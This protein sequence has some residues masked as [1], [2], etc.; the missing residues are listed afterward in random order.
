MVMPNILSDTT[1]R[2][3]EQAGIGSETVL[4]AGEI[5]YLRSTANLSTGGTAID[6]T[7]VV[8]PD[9]SPCIARGRHSDRFPVG[10]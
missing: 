7:D 5:F 10:A 1:T 4:P 9:C 8:H 3:M 6:M 2:L